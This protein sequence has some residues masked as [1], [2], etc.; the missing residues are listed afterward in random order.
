VPDNVKLAKRL[1]AAFNEGD[2]DAWLELTA[3]DAEMRDLANAPDQAESIKGK[4]AIRKAADLWAD[5]FDELRAEICEYTPVGDC[6]VLDAHWIGTGKGSGISIDLRQFD[7]YEFR[8]GKW[9]SAVIGLP[10]KEV[11]VKAAQARLVRRTIE[12]FN[13]R[14]IDRALDMAP[15]EFIMDW[16]NSIGPLKGVYRGRQEVVRLWSAFLD[17]W[18]S[19]RW[20]PEEIIE[21]DDSQVVVVNHVEM[22]G[23][24]SGVDIDATGV[25]LWTF[26][27]GEPQ[28]IKLFQSKEE[29]LE[30]AG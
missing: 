11:A 21:V 5:A 15:D 16:S 17:A 13:A 1:N 9:I 7:L 19:V 8:D 10:S 29:A 27:A 3:P 6:V 12:L 4:D 30:A 18:D 24:G 20:D 26:E 25:Q 22:R 2:V 14:E 23:R 28:R